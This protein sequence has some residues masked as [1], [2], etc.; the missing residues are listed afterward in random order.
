[1]TTQTSPTMD[2]SKELATISIRY[3]REIE[4]AK[5]PDIADQLGRSS[6]SVGANIHTDSK[7]TSQGFRAKLTLNKGFL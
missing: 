7:H 5:R 4:K 1:M 2:K 3:C 6:A